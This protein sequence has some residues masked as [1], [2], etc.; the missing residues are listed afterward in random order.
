MKKFLSIFSAVTLLVGCGQHSEVNEPIQGGATDKTL[1]RV[2]YAST[3]ESE[4][5]MQSRTYVKDDTKILW[6][7]GDDI[8]Y[9]SG[10]AHNV[11]YEYKGYDGT[12]EAVFEQTEQLGST[13]SEVA[14]SHAVY[15]YQEQCRSSYYTDGEVAE[16]Q[17]AVTYAAAQ[18]YRRNSFGRGANLMVASGAD[19]YDNKLHFRNACG[20]LVLKLYGNNRYIKSIKLTTNNSNDK[21]AGAATIALQSGQEPVTTMAA[22][23]GTEVTLDCSGYNDGCGVALTSAADRAIEF[24]FALPPVT[25]E[26]GFKAVII[27]MEDRMYEVSTQ[28][29]VEIVRNRIQPMEAIEYNPNC[30]ITYTR[31]EGVE[32]LTFEEA[33]QSN[34]FDANI[35]EHYYNE[36]LKRF[37]I[38]FDAPVTE[39]KNKAFYTSDITSIS[40]PQSLTTIGESVFSGSRIEN[41]VIPGNVNTIGKDTFYY[42]MALQSIKFLPSPDNAVLRIGQVSQYDCGGPFYVSNL[43]DVY[44]DREV[45]ITHRDGYDYTPQGYGQGLFSNPYPP[46]NFKAVLG[47]QVE[48]IT[49]FMFDETTISSLTIP[50]TVKT[51]KNNAFY[52]CYSLGTVVFEAGEE[53]IDVCVQYEPV[54]NFGGYAEQGP[55]YNCPLAS[56]TLNRE[57]RQIDEDGEPFEPGSLIGSGWEEGVFA[58]M[59]YD[60]DWLSTTV[61]IGEGVQNILKYMFCGVRM[62]SVTIPE[63]IK[64]IAYRAFY[65]CRCLKEVTC[66]SQ[67]PPTLGEK[68]F[69]DCPLTNIYVPSSAVSTYQNAT[70][71][72]SYSSKIGSK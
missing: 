38:K 20:Y 70:N 34:P 35:L 51:I 26:G 31:A 68:V 37:V 45:I 63:N 6:H 30:I 16:Q 48:T 58:N 22:D 29:T 19:S 2:V 15:P 41:L 64:T 69:E 57:I 7:G 4:T 21:I 65:D 46:E 24:W 8:S 12:T 23:A 49:E 60:E 40:L 28:K 10:T 3:A 18:T 43:N 54:T 56:I 14:F 5:D 53:P 47:P 55:F 71:W 67:T 17:I 11:R 52:T 13:G 32:P 33:E 66:I 50:S 59:Y 42:T 39:I 36:G 27:D 1:P 61:V 9:F 25:I 72:S 44:L 62:S